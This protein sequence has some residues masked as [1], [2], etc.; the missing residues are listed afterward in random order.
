MNNNLQCKLCGHIFSSP[1]RLK[2]HINRQT[3]CINTQLNQSIESC[4]KI[5]IGSHNLKIKSNIFFCQYCK[6]EFARQDNLSKHLK[7]NRCPFAQAASCPGN[8][9]DTTIMDTLSLV[10][11]KLENQEKQISQLIEKPQAQNITNNNLQI[12]CIGQNDNYLDMLTQQWGFDR[13]IDY[14]KDCA[15]SSLTGDCKLIEKI[16]IENYPNAINYTDKKKTKIQYFDE[17]K[18]KIIDN[19]VQFGRKVANNLQN[20]YLKGVNHLINEN[21][22]NHRCPNKFLQDYDIQ[23]WN[24]HIFDLSDLV[25]QKKIVNNLNIT[26]L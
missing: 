18:N 1:Q 26:Q 3:S 4:E 23:A 12:I 20:S 21:L 11:K 14:I 5:K 10:L 16:Y 13:A 19:K 9:S 8:T 25:Y 17:N 2:S 6:K 15:L 22:N 24:Q 7:L